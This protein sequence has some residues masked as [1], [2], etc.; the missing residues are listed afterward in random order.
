MNLSFLLTFFELINYVNA[1]NKAPKMDVRCNNSPSAFLP[2]AL[3]KTKLIWFR[4]LTCGSFRTKSLGFSLL[5]CPAHNKS[6]HLPWLVD[7]SCHLNTQAP[8]ILLPTSVTF[9]PCCSE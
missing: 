7:S 2:E 1:T 5:V 6:D 3:R 4:V 9:C 8:R